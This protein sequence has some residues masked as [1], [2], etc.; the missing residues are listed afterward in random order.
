MKK[1]YL[2]PE[3]EVFDVKLEGCICESLVIGGEGE[4]M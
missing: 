1:P 4:G 2:K 3:M